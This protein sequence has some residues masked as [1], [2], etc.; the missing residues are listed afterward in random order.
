[1]P[2]CLMN[3]KMGT[4]LFLCRKKVNH[5]KAAD[6]VMGSLD[7]QTDILS[8]VKGNYHLSLADNLRTASEETLRA[9]G[10]LALVGSK[11]FAQWTFTNNPS[12]FSNR[13][14]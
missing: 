3:Q 7:L 1:M 8:N 4:I 5:S 10:Y 11:A 2:E 13:S 6:H 9:E 12:V 14:S